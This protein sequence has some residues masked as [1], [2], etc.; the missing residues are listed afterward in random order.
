MGCHYYYR[1]PSGIRASQASIIK[2]IVDVRGNG[3]TH[4]GYV[5]GAASVTGKGSYVA[6]N[7][8]PVAECPPALVELCTD[9]ARTLLSPA[10]SEYVR[11]AGSG[12]IAGLETAVLTAPDGNRNNV[13]LWASRA[14]CAD[15][16]PEAD[17]VQTLGNAYV[18]NSGDG[19]Y[20]QAESTIRSAYRLQA[21]KM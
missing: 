2:G 16:I 15:G 21:A 11:P 12:G 1:W 18:T 13:L 17:A 19:G 6:E 5:L 20:R 4:G 9:G 14:A 10:V 3:G 7:K 8:L